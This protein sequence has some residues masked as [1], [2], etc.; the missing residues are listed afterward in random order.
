MGLA[1]RAT[2]DSGIE[3]AKRAIDDSGIEFAE[4]IIDHDIGIDVGGN[5]V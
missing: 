5:P 1:K 3:F 4:C 2:D